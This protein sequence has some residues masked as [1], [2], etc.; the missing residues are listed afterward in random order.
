MVMLSTLSPHWTL[1]AGTSGSAT[2]WTTII[3]FAILL[4]AGLAAAWSL[5]KG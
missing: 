1:A 5:K 4:V 3:A 2:T